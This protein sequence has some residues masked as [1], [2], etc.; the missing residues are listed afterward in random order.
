MQNANALDSESSEE[1]MTELEDRGEPAVVRTGP[2]W[3]KCEQ[4]SE[5]DFVCRKRNNKEDRV[6]AEGYCYTLL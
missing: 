6:K 2:A 1:L 4:D 3:L 5:Y